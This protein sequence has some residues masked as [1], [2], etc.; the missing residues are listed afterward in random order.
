MH[1]FSGLTCTF[2]NLCWELPVLL[3]LRQCSLRGPSRASELR[4]HWRHTQAGWGH[5]SGSLGILLQYFG[6]LPGKLETAHK[7]FSDLSLLCLLKQQIWWNPQNKS[8]FRKRSSS[9][10]TRYQNSWSYLPLMWLVS[11]FWP[12]MTGVIDNSDV[13]QSQIIFMTGQSRDGWIPGMARVARFMCL[14][15]QMTGLNRGDSVCWGVRGLCHYQK[16]KEKEE[17]SAA[18]RSDREHIICSRSRARETQW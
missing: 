6:S 11:I 18:H 7:I 17:G 15:S 10:E 3:P 12:Q 14:V 8:T 5:S 1:F 4:R 16:V 13:M 9:T 2:L